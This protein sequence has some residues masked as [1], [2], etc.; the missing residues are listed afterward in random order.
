MFNPLGEW[1][2][3][4]HLRPGSEGDFGPAAAIQM[5]PP[6]RGGGAAKTSEVLASSLWCKWDFKGDRTACWFYLGLW[7]QDGLFAGFRF[8]PPERDDNHNYYH[9]QPCKSWHFGGIH[10]HGALALPERTPTWPLPARS[11][12]D[13]LLC[14]IVSMQ[15]MRG[16]QEVFKDN[17]SDADAVLR[18]DRLIRDALRKIRDLQATSSP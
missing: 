9:S 12:L 2:L 7:L 10:V 3:E 4:R 8:E 6:Q 5:R 14:A 11:S 17:I 15:G 1:D 18:Q 16:L 13:L